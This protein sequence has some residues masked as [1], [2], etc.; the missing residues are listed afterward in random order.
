MYTIIYLLIAC[1]RFNDWAIF[2]NKAIKAID[3]YLN[4]KK[5][6]YLKGYSAIITVTDKFI[7]SLFLLLSICYEKWSSKLVN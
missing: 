7:E 6:E 3:C 4:K 2:P 5:F 1:K